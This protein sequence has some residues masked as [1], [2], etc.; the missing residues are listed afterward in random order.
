MN[1][2]VVWRGENPTRWPSAMVVDPVEKKLGTWLSS[3]REAVR[4]GPNSVF[5]QSAGRQK[6]LDARTPGWDV[7]PEAK[8][9]QTMNELVV[10]RG[11]NPTRW[12]SA[13]GVDLVEKKLSTW[14]TNQR[15]AARKGE[16]NAIFQSAGR[17]QILDAKTPGWDTATEAKWEQS[18][19]EL[20]VWRAENPM[21]WPSATAIDPVEKKLGTWLSHY[22]QVA[23]KSK[24][25]D[26]LETASRQQILDTKIPGWDLTPDAKWEQTL[27]KL[28]VWLIENPGRWPSAKAIDPADKVLGG[29][30]STQR[31]AA[32][33]GSS[34][35]SV[36]KT[37]RR[38][39]LDAAVPGWCP[40]LTK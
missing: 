19:N 40:P 11:E 26:L 23:R 8:W 18:M 17:R 5:F 39:L 25:N 27:G 33:G 34:A 30:L 1:E 10:W 20:V 16:R 31:T 7:A 32:R 2:L 21:R 28:V 22:R 35:T 38:Q 15:Q 6:V 9:E 36:A 13:S 14:L 29:W 24:H 12:P 37:N 4:G 3:Q